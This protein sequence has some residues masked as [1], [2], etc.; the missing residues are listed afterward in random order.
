MSAITEPH[1]LAAALIER[2]H[3]GD[4]ARVLDFACGSG[5]NGAALRAAGF[6]VVEVDDAA[7]GTAEPLRDISEP[8]DAAISTHGLL[9]GTPDA[10]ASRLRAI[11]ERLH[12]GGILHATLGSSR[13]ERFGR[14]LR[15]GD[16]TF[17]PL[18]G[19]ESGIPHTYYDRDRAV[20]MLV[21]HFHV[22]SLEE[23]DVDD[24]AGR[25]AHTARPLQ[26]A[27][28]WFAIARRR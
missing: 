21:P 3:A 28:H 12:T 26:G 4:G 8:F 18:D 16:W 9:H 5:R 2:L 23:A 24:V 7:A 19:D 1:P 6:T 25:W 20:A 13:D 15:L 22:E 14:G 27:V 11:A 10:I 17:A